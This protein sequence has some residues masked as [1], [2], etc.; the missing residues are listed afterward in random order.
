[1]RAAQADI[2]GGMG[3]HDRGERHQE[4]HEGYSR[5]RAPLPHLPLRD[6]S[7]RRRLARMNGGEG[8]EELGGGLA[9]PPVWIGAR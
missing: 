5:P 2:A 9:F 1:L 3:R 6:A 4:R 7:E 8:R